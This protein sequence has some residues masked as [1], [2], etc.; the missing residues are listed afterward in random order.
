[1]DGKSDTG[2][3]S[4]ADIQMY[5]NWEAYYVRR[6]GGNKQHVDISA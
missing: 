1:M 6:G 3:S 5:K 4:S 2:D